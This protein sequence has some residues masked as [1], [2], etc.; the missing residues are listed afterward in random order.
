MLKK[1]AYQGKQP[2]QYR[3]QTTTGRIKFEST[4][5]HAI[6]TCSG[7]EYTEVA[8]VRDIMAEFYKGNVQSTQSHM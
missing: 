7:H 1:K 3:M 8:Q 2:E 6:K 4:L 5:E